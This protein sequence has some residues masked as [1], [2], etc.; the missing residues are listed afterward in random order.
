MRL[1]R[2]Q[3]GFAP[4]GGNECSLT[5][6]MLD[7][8]AAQGGRACLEVA[9]VATTVFQ[10]PR[11]AQPA[12]KP[13]P[14]KAGSGGG[15][16]EGGLP[17][18]CDIAQTAPLNSPQPAVVAGLNVGD[19]LLVELGGD[20]ARPVLEVRTAANAIAGSLTHRGHLAVILCIEA[21]NAYEAVVMERSGGIVT[22]R[23]QRR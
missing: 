13:D 4:M 19:V 14:A 8:A 22:V 21:G 7:C 5:T 2:S 11:P 20:A 18:P 16:G 1:E 17:D 9:A 15:G 6:Q 23:I 12:Q 3:G 10:F